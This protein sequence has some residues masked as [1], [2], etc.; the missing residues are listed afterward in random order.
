MKKTV[1]FGL[2]VIVLAFGFIGCGDDDGDPVIREYPF[3]GDGENY[4]LKINEDEGTFELTVGGKTS[5]GTAVKSG[6]TWTLTPTGGNSFTVTVNGSGGITDME[7]EITFNDGSKK[8]APDTITPPPTGNVSPLE[9]TWVL[10]NPSAL[11]FISLTMV[12][13]GNTCVS[14][15][16][17]T[18]GDP[19]SATGTFEIVGST[20]RFVYN[21]TISEDP[22]TL[23]GTT[24]TM[25]SQGGTWVYT[26]TN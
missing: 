3:T 10:N 25:T 19:F 16:T 15:G 23:S 17:F 13:T 4:V 2:L 12:F 5:K 1:F 18:N 14:T 21:G 6:N 20:I 7:G 26:K 11:G 8:P 24:L 9:G 22:F